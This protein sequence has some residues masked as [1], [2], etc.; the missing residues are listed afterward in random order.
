MKV[1]YLE[2]SPRDVEIIRELLTDAGYDLSMDCAE[3]KMEFTSLLRSHTYD[4]ILSDFKLH[5]FDAFGAL[6]LA[7]DICPEV[8][9][10][11]ISGS[12]GEETAIEL[13]KQKAV[14]YVLKDRMVRLPFAIKRSLD[15]VKEK[16]SRRRAEEALR[17]SSEQYHITFEN[18]G[19]ANVIIE[20][21]TT[22]SLVNMEFEHLSGY[23]KDEIEGKKKWTEFVV[24]EDL[25]YMIAQHKLRRER[26][27]A[28][29]NQYEFRFVDRFGKIHN[30]LLHIEVI[31]ETKTSIASL[32][33]I[34]E[35]KRAEEALVKEQF[36]MNIMMDNIPDHIYF[37]DKDSRFIRINKSQAMRFGLSDSA[38]AV[39]KTDF[40]FFAE[41]HARPAFK[42]EQK[43]MKTGQPLIGLEEKETWP[44]G[45]ETWVTTTKMPLRDREGE[46]IGTFGI[47]KDIT[48]R[49]LAEEALRESETRYRSVLQSATD[50]IVTA[51]SSGIIVGWNSGAERIFGYSYT[52]AVGQ[53]LT[54]IMPLYRH[55]G[56]P[57][58]MNRLQSGGDQDVIEKTIELEGLRKDKSVFPIELS[59]STWETKAGQFF[60]GIARDITQRRQME[61]GLRQMQKLEG[62]GTLAG[63]IA[64]D[65]NNILGIILAYITSIKRFKDDAKN[66]GIAT[67][68]II[69]AVDRGKTLVKQILTFARK[70]ETEFGPVDVN[71]LVMEIMAMI[72]ETFTKVLTYSQ[73]FDEAVPYI[74]ADRSQ[75]YQALLNLCVNARDAM[76]NGGVLTIN[77]RMVSVASLRYQHPDADTSSYVCIEV[78]DT[79]EG[80]TEEIRKRIFEPFFTT[81]GIGKGTGLGLSVVFGVI[82]SHK[83]FIDVDSE[84]GKG[85]TFCLYLPVSQMA[86]PIIEKEKETLESIPGGTETLLVVEDEEMLLMPLQMVLGEKGYKVLSAQDGFTALKIYKEKKNEIALVLT[87]LGLPNISGLAVCQQIKAI[88]PNAHII[89]A[90]GYIEPDMK[91]ELLKVRIQHFLYKPYDLIKVLKEVREVL[92]EK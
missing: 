36:L 7:I 90:S 46:I 50:A 63:G 12:I 23:S 5:G 68:T 24:K 47:S 77:T 33:D 26:A 17:R 30:V 32:L 21:D 42:D 44:D 31:K 73:N 64:H 3:K 76:P 51:D 83:G 28:A 54:S 13:I 6:S 34:T 66:L 41:Q 16:N 20:E 14:D 67:E 27:E 82:Q 70:S 56:H 62:L 4:V 19:T 15:E 91:S 81:K 52:E 48:E 40:D 85:T 71:D 25:E 35:R 22:L 18:T 59:L 89:L 9:F 92:D 60:T 2:D 1:L 49:K 37:K 87:D 65:F 78:S 55:A 45:S 58:G 84:L 10:I 38:E 80:M 61:E 53:P 86:E 75:L 72:H 74:N 43:I 39:G 11:C 79:G 8:P 88:N 57:N 69:K 29:K